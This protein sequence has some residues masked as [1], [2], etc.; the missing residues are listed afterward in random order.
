MASQR[1][2][3][4]PREQNMEVSQKTYPHSI[5]QIFD[6][7]EFIYC[8]VE[9]ESIEQ[10]AHLF[11]FNFRLWCRSHNY[12]IPFRVNFKILQRLLDYVCVEKIYFGAQKFPQTSIDR[13][14]SLQDTMTFMENLMSITNRIECPKNNTMYVCTG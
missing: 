10:P 9:G 1:K 2:K 5:K 11:E 14:A 6:K 13:C 3:M 4:I 12:F 7:Y 8:W